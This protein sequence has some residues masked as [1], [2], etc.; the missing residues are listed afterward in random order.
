MAR[1]CWHIRRGGRI[2]PRLPARATRQT[3]GLFPVTSSADYGAG[4]GFGSRFG[5]DGVRDNFARCQAAGYVLR[6]Q[7]F[8][9]LQ[10]HFSHHPMHHS[11]LPLASR[12]LPVAALATFLLA[13]C[14]TP[15]L[16]N[17]TPDTLPA[18]P[19]QLYTLSTRFT[20]RHAKVVP[21]SVSV[22]VFIGREA[23]AMSLSPTAPG[24]YTYDFPAPA[25]TGDISYYFLA[26]YRA[27]DRN[28]TAIAHEEF[29]PLLRGSILGRYVSELATNRG[30]VGARVAILGTGF[31]KNDLIYLDNTPAAAEFTEL[32]SN[33][34]AFRVPPVEAG[35]NYTV[36]VANA[37]GSVVAG[38]FHVDALGAVTASP[39]SLSLRVG[40]AQVLTLRLPVAAPNDGLLLDLETEPGKESLVK[41]PSALVQAGTVGINVPVTGGATGS[42]NLILRGYGSAP[43][44][45]PVT[46]TP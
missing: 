4:D 19:S 28:G 43:L 29:T 23:H 16:T 18:N 2:I 7:R 5:P 41:I 34:L 26:S 21:G 46:V 37:N 31:T 11:R 12:F 6:L 24:L 14:S 35:K 40:Q 30:P 8:F 17:L 42:G 9:G 32:S 15:A 27:L 44:V 1:G 22:Q 25:G 13:G 36:R 45:I 39:A 10:K 3:S 38:T 33:A 20:P